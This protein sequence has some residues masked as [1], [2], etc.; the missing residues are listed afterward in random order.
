MQSISNLEAKRPGGVGCLMVPTVQD[1]HGCLSSVAEWDLVHGVDP[2][3][4]PPNAVLGLAHEVEEKP[5]GHVL[6]RILAA[7][8]VQAIVAVEKK[9][10]RRQGVG[11][12]ER[13]GDSLVIPCSKDWHSRSAEPR[14][15][16]MSELLCVH[17]RN[18][19]G[20]E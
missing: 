5:L 20:W 14:I 10:V 6:S 13:V 11:A 9:R 1:D 17:V 15:S 3:L 4:P 18:L 16:R 19:R 2:I 12:R 8:V 7:P